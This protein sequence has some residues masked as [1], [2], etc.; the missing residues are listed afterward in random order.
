MGVSQKRR[1]GE[2][3]KEVESQ[4]GLIHV[5]RMDSRGRKEKEMQAQDR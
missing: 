4:V 3:P 2:K 1:R 5:F